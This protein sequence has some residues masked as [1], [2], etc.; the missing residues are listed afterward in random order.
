MLVERLS[1]RG[2]R[3][4]HFGERVMLEGRLVVRESS[5]KLYSKAAPAAIAR[6]VFF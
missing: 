5:G 4:S 2:R 3:G 6:Q 1:R